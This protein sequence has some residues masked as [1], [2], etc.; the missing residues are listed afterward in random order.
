VPANNPTAPGPSSAKIASPR[1]S[2]IAGRGT[3]V[4]REA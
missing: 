3:E 4:A 1:S 2:P